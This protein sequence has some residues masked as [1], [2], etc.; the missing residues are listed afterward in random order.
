L[1]VDEDGDE[2]EDEDE[3]EGDESEERAPGEFKWEVRINKPLKAAPEHLGPALKA[4]NVRMHEV[5]DDIEKAAG[6]TLKEK[7]AI[8]K[9]NAA[10]LSQIQQ[11]KREQIK[12]KRRIESTEE[13]KQNKKK[14][15]QTMTNG[16]TG[17]SKHLRQ[18]DALMKYK[19]KAEGETSD[20]DDEPEID[21]ELGINLNNNP[22]FSKMTDAK[23]KMAWEKLAGLAKRTVGVYSMTNCRCVSNTPFAFPSIDFFLPRLD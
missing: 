8:F 17:K 23:G 13:Q 21:P 12:A 5:E 20:D 3:D 9:A 15:V 2:D 10:K 1:F 11:D 14:S 18:L 4:E 19:P 7:M 16:E 22:L 6:L